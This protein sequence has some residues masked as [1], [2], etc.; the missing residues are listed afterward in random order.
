MKKNNYAVIMAGGIGSRFWP[1]STSSKPK[2][3]LDVLGTGKSLIQLTFDRIKH[4]CVEE[5]ILIVTSENYKA[6]VQEQLPQLP[7]DNILC[8]PARRNTAPCVAYG[9]YKILSKNK[10]AKILIAPSDHLILKELDYLSAIEKGFKACENDILVT[11]GIE[12]TRPDTGYGYIKASETVFEQ[13]SD[14]RKVDVF[15][16]KP[17]LP[18]AKEYHSK[19]DFYWNSGMFIW[20]ALSIT[21]AF[22]NCSPAMHKLFSS[23]QDVYNTSS[24]KEF[25][26]SIYNQCENI[27][28]DYAIMEKASNVYVLP[29]DIGWTDLGTWG[30]LHDTLQQDENQNALLGEKIKVF[31]A[32]NNMIANNSNKLLVAHGLKGFIV[33]NT[34]EATLICK[35]D[36]EQK[37]K[38]FVSELSQNEEFKTLF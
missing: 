36:E 7:L 19:S 20:S 30:S 18:L 15:T 32:E 1:M 10:D 22:S 29:C 24:E 26:D 33:V 27:S 14:F 34:A 8:E 6:L 9:C 25:I 23:G 35:L 37:I 4:L 5:N 16:E 21:K 28:V 38:K 2:Q 12:T 3:F 17:A 31:E 13:D 11:L